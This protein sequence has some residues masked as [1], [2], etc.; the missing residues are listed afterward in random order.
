MPP[1]SWTSKWRMR[2]ARLPA[3]RTTAN[4]SGSSCSIASRSACALSGSAA[5]ATAAAT[6]LRNS[7][8]FARSAA[9][10]SR[11]MSGSS[12]L[13]RATVREY[14]FSRRSLRLPK[15]LVRT[16]AIE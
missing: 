5:A 2:S 9:S 11:A 7:S 10:S 13:M 12:A 16:L 1:S 14:C 3:S 6:R 8:V 4:A 15:I